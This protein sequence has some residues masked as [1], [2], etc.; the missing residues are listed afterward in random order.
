MGQKGGGRHGGGG[1][2][3]GIKIPQSCGHK[4]THLNSRGRATNPPIVC[5][6]QPPNPERSPGLLEVSMQVAYCNQSGHSRQES[7]PWLCVHLQ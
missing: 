3:G 4:Q 5:I 7:L 2:G 1:G 6:Y